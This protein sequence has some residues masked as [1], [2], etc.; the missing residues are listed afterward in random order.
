MISGGNITTPKTIWAPQVV[1]HFSSKSSSTVYTKP[2]LDLVGQFFLKMLGR[3]VWMGRISG[4]GGGGA[5]G[6][7][8]MD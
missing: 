1:S 3:H 6:E 5:P 7:S 4:G 8:T 2:T